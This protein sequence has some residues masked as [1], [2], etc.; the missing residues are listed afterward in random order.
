M[1]EL[2]EFKVLRRVEIL[3]KRTGEVAVAKEKLDKARTTRSKAADSLKAARVSLATIKKKA[4]P[5]PPAAKR[6]TAQPKKGSAAARPAVCTVCRKP[7]V[8]TPI[9]KLE[10]GCTFHL[11]CIQRW[12]KADKQDCPTCLAPDL[13]MKFRG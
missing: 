2:A 8:E 13:F 10:C 5:K 12:V 11:R 4:L 9:E 6:I 7:A 1:A 3:D